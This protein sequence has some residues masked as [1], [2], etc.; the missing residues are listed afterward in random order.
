MTNAI[1]THAEIVLDR[2]GVVVDGVFDLIAADLVPKPNPQA[3][4]RF[5]ERFGVQ[6]ERAVMVDD[7]CHNLEVPR[8]MGMRTI[9]LDHGS[10]VVLADLLTSRSDR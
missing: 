3:H 5:V 4:A 10:G 7:L 1:A 6:P 9:W 8:Q 2:L